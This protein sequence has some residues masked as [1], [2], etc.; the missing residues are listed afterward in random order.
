LRAEAARLFEEPKLRRLLI[1]LQQ[2]SKIIVGAI[3]IDTL[4]SAGFDIRWAEQ[5]TTDFRRSVEQIKDELTA[6]QI[7]FEQ[8]RGLL[9]VKS[10]VGGSA[11]L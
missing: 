6:L 10:P 1:D 9:A 11:S 5:R 3:S 7:L 4:L 8:P 2:I